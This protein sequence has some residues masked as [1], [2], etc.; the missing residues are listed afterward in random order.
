[1]EQDGLQVVVAE[2]QVQLVVQD[3]LYLSVLRHMQVAVLAALV[4]VTFPVLV[5]LTQLEAA[6][7]VVDGTQVEGQEVMVVPVL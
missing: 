2:L 7:V 5:E 1:V 6:A 3:Q 4:E